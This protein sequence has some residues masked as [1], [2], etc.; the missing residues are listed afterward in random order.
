MPTWCS[1]YIFSSTQ[2]A[3]LQVF[4]LIISIMNGT[5][6][7]LMCLLIYRETLIF[8]CIHMFQFSSEIFSNIT[9]FLCSHNSIISTVHIV[10]FPQVSFWLPQRYMQSLLFSCTW[11]FSSTSSLFVFLSFWIDSSQDSSFFS[12]WVCLMITLFKWLRLQWSSLDILHYN[13]L[14][15]ICFLWL[16]TLIRFFYITAGWWRHMSLIPALGRQR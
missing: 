13:S 8:A 7:L 10:L 9:H 14:A 3:L 6:S 15:N 5:L 12:Q 11:F 16:L 1:F 4:L 2:Y